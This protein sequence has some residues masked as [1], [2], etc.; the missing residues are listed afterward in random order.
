MGFDGKTLIHPSQIGPCNDAF[1]PDGD[2]IQQARAVLAAF[3]LPENQGKGAIS[4]NGRM[5]ELLHAE[6]ARQ[7]VALADA[8]AA[9]TKD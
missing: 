4:L 8:I 3:A 5:V 6:I 2:E 7:T 9:L 1:S